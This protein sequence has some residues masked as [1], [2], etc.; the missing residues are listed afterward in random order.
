MSLFSVDIPLIETERLILRA[1]R[2]DDFA[3][4]AAFLASDR[5]RFVGGPMDAPQAFR[6]LL[7]S[8]GHWLLRGYGMW[9]IALRQ[10]DAPV[11][12]VGFL[13]GEGWDE[14]EL[15]WHVFS[16][17]EGQG[18]AFEAALAA[19]AHGAAQFGLTGVISYIDPAN[20]RSLALARRLGA[21]FE[22][23]GAVIGKPAQVWRHPKLEALA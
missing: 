12:R 3:A 23:D 10:D 22:R 17:Y 8:L 5:S 1:P 9:T 11:G 4:L 16:G 20:S 7:A 6:S 13:Y 19:R 14:P 21:Q 18:L 15:G 2:E